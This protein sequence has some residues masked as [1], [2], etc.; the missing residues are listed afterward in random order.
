MNRTKEGK[1]IGYQIHTR[2]Y[3]TNKDMYKMF[4]SELLYI[5]KNW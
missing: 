3:K 5:E 2:K 4:S 1:K